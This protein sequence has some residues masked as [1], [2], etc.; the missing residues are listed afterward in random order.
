[1]RYLNRKLPWCNPTY[2][3][4]NVNIIRNSLFWKKRNYVLDFGVGCCYEMYLWSCVLHLPLARKRIRNLIGLQCRRRVCRDKARPNI[5]RDYNNRN[6]KRGS[7]RLCL[8]GSPHVVP[9]VSIVY[10]HSPGVFI[11]QTFCLQSEML[12]VHPPPPSH[13]SWSD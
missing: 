9:F 6:N 3:M 12:S 2:K 4:Y 1:M 5:V 13:S 11:L 7:S 8:F 10:S